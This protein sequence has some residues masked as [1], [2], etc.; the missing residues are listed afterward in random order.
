MQYEFR[1]KSK[2]YSIN[3]FYYRD[4]RII[5][6]EAKEWMAQ[7]FHLLSSSENQEKLEQIRK[8]FDKNLHYFKVKLE[9]YFPKNTL[10]N[11]KGLLS[12]RAFDL[13]N[14]EKTLIDLIFLPKYHK[15]QFPYGC[16]NINIDDKYICE[17]ESIKG[18]SS[19][20]NY[21]TRIII[22]I[23]PLSEILE[24]N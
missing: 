10:F 16:P 18:L 11:K 20:Y 19:D 14:I 17:L 8:S 9:F 21:E 4:G 7:I 24:I 23:L 22:K 12:S 6:Q 3:S 1:L 5:K 15:Q 2:P 13:S